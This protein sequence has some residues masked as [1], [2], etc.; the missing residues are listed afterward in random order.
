MLVASSLTVIHGVNTHEATYVCSDGEAKELV[1]LVSSRSISSN[2]YQDGIVNVAVTSIGGV[3]TTGVTANQIVSHNVVVSHW[4]LLHEFHQVHTGNQF[5][6]HSSQESII[7]FP[8]N[9]SCIQ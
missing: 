6:P 9:G 5:S 3:H 1:I 8:H 4:Q 2:V 7:P